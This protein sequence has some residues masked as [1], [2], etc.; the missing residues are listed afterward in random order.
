MAQIP[1]INAG[2]AQLVDTGI[3][4]AQTAQLQAGGGAAAWGQALQN[5]GEMGVKF[6]QQR[7]K[8][9]DA[10]EMIRLEGEM[11]KL[12]SDQDAFQ[13][14][15][16]DQEAWAKAWQDRTKDFDTNVLKKARLSN[17]ARLT[18]V[19]TF[20]QFA[21]NRGLAIQR[22]ATEFANRNLRFE[23]TNLMGR[24]SK[25]ANAQGVD[26]GKQLL[27]AGGVPEAEAE[28]LAMPFREQAKGNYKEQ[29]KLTLDNLARGGDKEGIELM[30][31]DPEVTKYY[32]EEELKALRRDFTE[33]ADV[34]VV[35]NQVINDL[36]TDPPGE[37]M[38]L[39]AKNEDG[40]YKYYPTMGKAQ[41]VQLIQ[42]GQRMTKVM[43][44]DMAS[45]L[46]EKIVG[47]D[48]RSM[49]DLEKSENL[50]LYSK[51]PPTYKAQ[52]DQMLQEG[53]I[54]DP[55]EYQKAITRIE[56]TDL[57]DGPEVAST[58]RYLKMFAPEEQKMLL[59]RLDKRMTSTDKTPRS[60]ADLFQE[61]DD[62]LSTGVFGDYRLTG[63]KVEL[64]DGTGRARFKTVDNNWY[65]VWKSNDQL[66]DI[67]LSEQDRLKIKTAANKSTVVVEDLTKKRTATQ[68]LATLKEQVE[69]KIADGESPA[70]ARVWYLEQTK[71]PRLEEARKALQ[72]TNSILFPSS[73]PRI[74]LVPSA[75]DIEAILKSNGR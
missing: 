70:E 29:T 68:K 48:I 15:N 32:N 36:A 66:T 38:R 55:G 10:R 37:T 62:D 13:Q 64:E 74:E 31:A 40:S 41:R 25:A 19:S 75:Q 7:Q 9:N 46:Q 47:R 3:Q 63:E 57:T 39:D 11:R 52:I 65:E 50:A 67:Q 27:V 43:H 53:P 26:A 8:A 24:E 56:A 71:S 1:L 42:E 5:V 60:T 69:R 4:V 54:T 21:D 14:Q 18:M 34:A 44:N 33:K 51:L 35:E 17:D 2:Q 58:Q 16:K 45:Q 12:V 73:Q 49:K 20:G 22:D 28:Y 61:M 59:E 6:V 23:A 72:G 30:L